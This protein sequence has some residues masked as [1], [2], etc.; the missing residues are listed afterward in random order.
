[1]PCVCMCRRPPSVLTVI[2]LRRRGLMS[3]VRPWGP[4]D[5]LMPEML[6]LR[7]TPGAMLSSLRNLK[8]MIS[9]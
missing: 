3:V 7:L 8:A 5:A 1:M 6:K 4:T 2:L 9:P